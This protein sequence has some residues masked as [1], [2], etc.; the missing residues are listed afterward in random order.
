MPTRIITISTATGIF[1]STDVAP[2]GYVDLA[3]HVSW[4]VSFAGPSTAN[5]DYA[6]TVEGSI[7]NSGIWNT[8]LTLTTSN[9]TGQ[10]NTVNIGST[11]EVVLFDKLRI[12]VS[13]NNTT[14]ETGVW[15]AVLEL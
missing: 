6:G 14:A 2:G 10:V 5:K 1:P 13:K 12:N 15:L 11:G 3:G 4:A 7:G 8:I 9:T